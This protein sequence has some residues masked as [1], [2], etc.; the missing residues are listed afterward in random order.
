MGKGK[1]GE[2]IVRGWAHDVDIT[3]NPVE[4]DE[5]G[6]DLIFEF[7]EKVE[8]QGLTADLI[9]K[10]IQC[11]IQ[12]KTTHRENPN[13]QIKL[14][15]LKR[16]V[17]TP[18]PSFYLEL[19]L[20]QDN[21]PKTAHI[22]HVGEEI[23]RKSLKKMRE[24]G[25]NWQEKLHKDKNKM[26]L[27]KAVKEELSSA[28]G[29]G[30]KKEIE[31]TIGDDFQKYLDRK[32]SIKDDSGYEDIRE[33]VRF[34]LVLPEDYDGSIEEYLVDLELGIEPKA[35]IKNF[36][37]KDVRFGIPIEV[38]R[39]EG[40]YLKIS[41]KSRDVI[42]TLRTEDYREKIQI[43]ADLIVPSAVRK[44]I[45]KE[46]IKIRV[47]APNIELDFK[48]FQASNNT[49]YNYS[50]PSFKQDT[51]LQDV[52]DVS[53]LIWFFYKFNDL[54]DSIILEISSSHDKGIAAK[55][56]N[57]VE[58]PQEVIEIAFGVRNAIRIFEY[59]KLP[60]DTKLRLEDIHNQFKDIQILSKIIEPKHFELNLDYDV[61]SL[62]DRELEG[63]K[64]V[65]I[66]PT[67]L[68]FGDK[69]LWAIV[70]CRGISEVVERNGKKY[71][72]SFT[73]SDNVIEDYQVW[74]GEIDNPPRTVNQILPDI[75]EKYE[76]E[77]YLIAPNNNS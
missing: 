65:F 28:D 6:W 63:G 53:N 8:I 5:T 37:E 3:P 70:S 43:D 35:E 50:F 49:Q 36:V 66:N 45:S 64:A 33:N 47:E 15:N 11:W 59:C 68:S 4:N 52:K 32:K 77:Y 27:P 38:N 71:E 48:P 2:I 12:V 7:P 61:E 21:E 26:Q 42:L 14:S 18:L 20:D 73:S 58:F 51:S 19:I 57:K 44:V 67:K 30:L 74:D 72:F 1:K 16:L 17:D 39:E 23:I 60:L 31:N 25:T 56:N 46:N 10:P 40:G 69:N 75:K 62:V 34:N 54:K 41:K 22:F 55:I 24:L 29:E 13:W 76:G 9:P